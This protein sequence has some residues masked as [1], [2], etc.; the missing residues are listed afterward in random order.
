MISYRRLL[1]LVLLLLL[2]TPV[3]AVDLPPLGDQASSWAASLGHGAVGTAEKR[4]GKWTF[5]LAGE[6]FAAGHEKVPAE[7]VVFEIGSISKV[8]TGVLL[9]K[10][11]QEGKLGLGDTLAQRLPG[12]KFGDPAVGALTLKQLGT[13]TSCLP[14]LPD[15]LVPAG[16]DPYSQYDQKALFDYL[17]GA[18]LGKTAPCEPSYSNLGFGVLGNVLEVAYGKP[19]AALVQEKIAGPLGMTDTVQDLSPEQQARFAEPWN[20][21]LKAHPWTLKSMAGAGALRSTLGDMAKFADALLAGDKG[22]LGAAW[23]VLAG[24]YVDMPAVG[25]KIGLAILH[26]QA[27]GEESYQHDGGTGGFRSTLI[28]YPAKGHAAVV[29]ASNATANPSA[30]LA[31]WAAGSRPSVARTEVTLPAAALDEYPGVYS[32]DKTARFTILRRGE[33]LVARLTG[34]PFFPVFAT[35]KDEFFYKVVDARLSF[36]RN[37]EGKVDRLVLHQNGRDIPA[38]RDDVPAPQI[39]FPDAAALA[40]YAGEYDFGAFIPGS[41]IAARATPDGLLVTLTGQPELPVFKTGTDRFEYDVVVAS[42]TFERNP[43][44][45]VVAVVLHQ[46]GRDLRA[47]RK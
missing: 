40:D 29:L 4:T 35:A 42:L 21:S 5:A 46:G 38:S 39:E 16:D 1:A 24:D 3:L 23:P 17:A 30:W 44:G 11:V 45:K 6:P 10:A 26:T 14:R 15:N 13:H 47:P 20:G 33:G 7:K 18:R 41:K 8:F 28:F 43:E 32:V 22:P 31:A 12:V 27:N 36:L 37:A 34:Q 25:G 19:W 2:A 9:A